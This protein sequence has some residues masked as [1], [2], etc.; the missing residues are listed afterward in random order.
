MAALDN[1]K[2]TRFK[3]TVAVIIFMMAMSAWS[4]AVK[5]TEVTIIAMGVVAASGI[6]YKHVETQNKSLK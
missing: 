5:E 4:L 6:M 2:R 1:T 3:V